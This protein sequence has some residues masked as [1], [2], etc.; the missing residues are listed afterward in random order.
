MSD[1]VEGDIWSEWLLKRRF[2]SD[3]AVAAQWQERLAK[4][5]EGV[6]DRAKIEPGDAVLD[7]GAG[8]GLIAF[9][10]LERVGPTGCVIF[11]DISQP[12]LDESRRIARQL[13][14]E[15]RCDFLNASAD[16]LSALADGSVDVVTVRSVLIYV[17]EKAASFREFFRVL[18]PGGRVSLFEPINR[19]GL[20][21]RELFKARHPTP[22]IRDLAE[23]MTKYWERLQPP[24]DPMLDFDERDLLRLALQA[25]FEEVHLRLDT[26]VTLSEPMSWDG[27]IS[28]AGNPK[29]PSLAEA[30]R[31]VFNDEEIMRYERAMRP[32]VEGGGQP[33]C[34]AVGWLQATKQR[35]EDGNGR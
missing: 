25:G 24:D 30:M 19:T 8:D 22:E 35:A 23:R 1:A 7:V 14:V 26:D 20:D 11:S 6:L 29:I 15:D 33:M 10:A 17:K 28:S 18:R 4:M 5:R 16:D 2:P 27:W 34:M 32:V 13:G 21:Y 12:L 3:P 9:G 31:E